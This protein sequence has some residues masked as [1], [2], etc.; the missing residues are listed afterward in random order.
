MS[1]PLNFL[2]TS[3]GSFTILPLLTIAASLQ[4]VA[5][6]VAM[7]TA[8]VRDSAAV[9]VRG[10]GPSVAAIGAVRSNLINRLVV[11]NECCNL[12]LN[13]LA[14]SISS[15]NALSSTSANISWSNVFNVSNF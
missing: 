8:L 14:C 2:G 10:L 12:S 13:T 3:F 6:V 5:D 11:I 15:S 7:M 4:W 1:S 9:V